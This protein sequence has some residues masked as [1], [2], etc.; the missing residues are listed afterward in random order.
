LAVAGLVALGAARA[1]AGFST[2]LPT[3]HAS[4][5]NHDGILSHLYGGTFTANGVNY[6][7]GSVTATR[8]EDTGGGTLN[9]LGLGNGADDQVWTDGQLSVHAVAR[10]A[11][12]DQSLGY[13]L[14]ADGSG[15]V[16]GLFD[17]VGMGFNVTG[18]ADVDM[19]GQTYRWMRGG[20]G[21]MF[22]SDDS[23]DQMVSYLITGTGGAKT[24]LL[25]W[26]DVRGAGSDRDYND[27]VVEV[28]AHGE[29]ILQLPPT[30]VPLPPAV[31]S[32]LSMLL[33]GGLWTAR[34]KI[35]RW[36]A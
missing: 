33:G 36:L 11:G 4:E 31:W 30:A 23:V 18:S 13:T 25:C 16:L 20:G 26:E 15:S 12:Y 14:G 10:F 32:G 19:T 28:T 17:V 9:A 34:R 7:N 27:L 5:V 1:D 21:E 2:V 29:S 6:S 24:W 35:R 22:S 8:I 3:P